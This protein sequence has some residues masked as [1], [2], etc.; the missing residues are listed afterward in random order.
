MSAGRSIRRGRV[1]AQWLILAAALTVLAGLVVAWALADAAERTEVVA[2]A[3]PVEAG[4]SLGRDDL[5]V[6]LVAVDGGPAGLV[7]PASIDALVGRT[8]AI[9]LSPGTLLTTG[10]WSEPTGLGAHERTVGAVL[11]ATR[12]PRDLGRGDLALAVS[13]EPPFESP[14]ADDTTA[15][16][17]PGDVTATSSPD[18]ASSHALMTGVVPVR[19]IDTVD[20][21]GGPLTVTLA[22][23]EEHAPFVAR[24][25][26]TDSLVLVG[27]PTDGPA[28]PSDTPVTPEAPPDSTVVEDEEA[29][30]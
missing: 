3:R 1:Q 29:G 21:D 23:A 24:L 20:G 2:I 12:V 6:A 8:A 26:A 22:V 18:P 25:A 9:D 5:T 27:V 14:S 28:D 4:A 13:V 15:G 16:E 17:N 19:V 7:D 11:D 30:S 10:M